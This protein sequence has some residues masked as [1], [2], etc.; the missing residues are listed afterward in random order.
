[1]S[2]LMKSQAKVMKGIP[3]PKTAEKVVRLMAR[4][5][6]RERHSPMMS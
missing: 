3:S 2:M 1:M 4:R 6:T 5:S